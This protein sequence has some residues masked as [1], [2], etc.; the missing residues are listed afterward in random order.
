MLAMLFSKTFSK[1]RERLTE[2]DR[3]AAAV[4]E[5]WKFIVS[6]RKMVK[7]FLAAPTPNYLTVCSLRKFVEFSKS[8]RSREQKQKQEM[9][10]L[11][12]CLH[13]I[14]VYSKFENS[15]WGGSEIV[16]SW[17][18]RWPCV[19][20]VCSVVSAEVSRLNVSYNFHGKSA[21]WKPKTRN[22]HGVTSPNR[23]RLDTTLTAVAKRSEPS[24]DQIRSDRIRSVLD[25]II[26][27]NQR[28]VTV[29]CNCDCDCP[30]ARKLCRKCC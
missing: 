12:C 20:F 29:N 21:M 26:K 27:I 19:C 13:R 18:H 17:S 11:P 2:S 3:A 28:P 4:F 6:L 10:L 15:R 24:T 1:L 8:V 30:V 9:L 22:S 16:E 14:Y 25:K 7:N 5:M 23:S